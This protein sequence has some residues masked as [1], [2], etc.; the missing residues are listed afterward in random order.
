M[1]KVDEHFYSRADEHIKLSNEQLSNASKGKVSASMMFSVA[2]FNSWISASRFNNSTEMKEAKEQT[3]NYFLD[4]Y[5]KMLTDN[6]D[7]YI[8]R[9]DTYMGK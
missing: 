2:R 7:D 4:E 5:K 9:F 3:I 8:Q 1:T 6:M